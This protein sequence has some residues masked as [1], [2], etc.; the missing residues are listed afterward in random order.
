MCEKVHNLDFE[1]STFGQL[2]GII[3]RCAAVAVRP[4]P[5]LFCQPVS[6]TMFFF[7]TPFIENL[8]GAK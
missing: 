4:L 5:E 8:R 7:A 1:F 6:G 3:S 2:F